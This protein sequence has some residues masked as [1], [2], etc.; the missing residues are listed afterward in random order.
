MELWGLW[1]TNVL[2]SALPPQGHRPDRWAEHQD[3]V[4]H[5]AQKKSEN[6]RKKEENKIKLL[7]LEI[8]IKNKK[9]NKS[10]KKERKKRATKPINKYTNDDK[11]WKLSKNNPTDRTLGQIVKAKLYRQNHTKKHTYTHS[12]K[13]KKEKIY[14]YFKKKRKRATKSINKSNGNKLYILH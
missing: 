9:I 10:F 8:I 14:L 5:T 7:K 11:R 2:N 6:K 12:Q 13:E 1:W 3:P 4:S